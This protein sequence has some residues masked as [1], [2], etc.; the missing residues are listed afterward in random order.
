[1]SHSE[2]APS[3][4]HNDTVLS[5]T[6]DGVTTLTINRPDKYNALN[7]QVIKALARAIKACGEDTATR[8]VVL[9]GAGDKA[10][11]AGADIG[12]LQ[13]LDAGQAERFVQRGHALMESIEN[14]GKPVI[15]AINGFALGGGCELALACTLRVA[16]EHAQIG[17]PEVTLG[18]LPGYGGTQR[19][20]RL[21]GRGRALDLM[22]T[23]E[24][25]SAAEAHAM[26]LVSRVFPAGEFDGAVTKL[27]GKLAKGAPLAMR[28]I[29][30]AVGEGA[31]LQLQAGL[32]EETCQFVGICQTE[33][34]REGTSAFLE[35]RRPDFKGR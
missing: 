32:A 6:A 25:V 3:Q 33:D 28:S 15:A 30:H 19:M 21:V 12:E 13:Q 24:P 18:L 8:V 20:S 23:G 14:L 4:A 35:K 34:M 16:S 2:N 17:L 5:A 29:I 11:V 9:T 7:Q 27:A 22:L 26:G 10:F 1:M 31:D